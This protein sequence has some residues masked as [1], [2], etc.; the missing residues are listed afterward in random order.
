MKSAPLAAL[1]FSSACLLTTNLGLR[2]DDWPQ[3]RGPNRD[4]ISGETGWSYTWPVAGPAKVWHA[5]VGIGYGTVSVSKGRVYLLGNTAESDT[6]YCLDANTG[7][8]LWKYSYPC[9]AKDPNG[10]PG[11]RC[12]PTVDGESVFTLS[13][14][15]NLFC[16]DTKEGKVRWAK[17]LRQDFGGKVPTWGYSTSP[18]VEG[19]LVIVEPGAPGASVAALKKQT[20]EV[21]WKAG[22]DP[23]AYS[24]P[25]AFTGADG[26][27]VLDFMAAN[28]VCRSLKD[29]HELWRYEW[30]TSWAVNAATPILTGD[31]KVFISSDYNTGCALLDMTKNPPA[32]LWKNK[33][34]RNHNNSCVLWKGY[35]YGFDEKR[36]FKCLELATG[37]VK[38]SEKKYGKGSLMVADGKLIIYSDRGKLGVADPSPDAYKELAF[39]TVFDVK[40]PHPSGASVD[41]WAVP[42]LAN[43][44]L[45]CRSLDEL[46]C[47]NLAP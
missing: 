1:L 13:R 26:R 20:G 36:E 41:T 33:F 45:Y 21:A 34:M 24:S 9:I 2:G 12:T 18:L 47:L 35:L 10:Y 15:G 17:D 25:I 19:D 43:G 27:C 38:W 39:T 16:L 42:V 30:V 29:G 22:D 4:G 7:A 28:L 11:P 8:T 14:Q 6:A 3:W 46:V 44:K 40:S 23:T 5:D 31:G 32:T 37:A